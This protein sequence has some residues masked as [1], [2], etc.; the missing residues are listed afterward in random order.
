M[1]VTELSNRILVRIIT[2]SESGCWL[3]VGDTRNGYGRIRT[4]A[5]KKVTYHRAH[6]YVYEILVGP[7]PEGYHL[8]HICENTL[9][10]NPEHM[11]PKTQEEHNKIHHAKESCLHGH[12]FT[13]ENTYIRS[14]GTKS[15]RACNRERNKKYN[16]KPER[17]K[18]QREYQKRRRQQ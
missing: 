11:E 17:K 5:N 16:Q 3:W 4:Y 7:I 18:Y 10:V 6:R 12:I 2:N 15:C 8:H 13:A 9:C 14:N 1:D